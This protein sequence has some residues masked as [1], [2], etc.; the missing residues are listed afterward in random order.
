ML[1]AGCQGSLPLGQDDDPDGQQGPR[2]PPAPVNL[3]VRGQ[4]CK[5]AHLMRERI[6]KVLREL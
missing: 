3:V 2:G 1:R 5:G 4:G 6:V